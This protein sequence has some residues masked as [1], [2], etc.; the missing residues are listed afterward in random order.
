MK[1][2]PPAPAE[3]PEELG[4]GRRAAPRC[5]HSNALPAART[6]LG[7]GRG[8]AVWLRCISRAAVAMEH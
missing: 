2:F 5:L 1:G 4:V 8:G 7:A 6:A 3:Y